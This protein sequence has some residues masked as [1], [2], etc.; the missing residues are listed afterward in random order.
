MS[1]RERE[2]TGD[3]ELERVRWTEGVERERE[4]ENRTLLGGRV[5]GVRWREKE[6][7][8]DA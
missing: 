2:T 1:E 6:R 7:W 5:E 8:T 4:V 3:G